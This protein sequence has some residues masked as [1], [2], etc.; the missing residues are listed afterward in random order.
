MAINFAGGTY[1]NAAV[2]TIED[3]SDEITLHGKGV[4]MAFCVENTGAALTAFQLQ[5]KVRH[6][7]TFH[8]V[9]DGSDWATTHPAVKYVKGTLATLASGASGKCVLELG[10][11][12]S[13]KFRASCGTTTATSLKVNARLQS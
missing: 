10:P 6:D 12:H 8:T 4:D 1:T 5:A 2:T 13:I 3:V 9:L 7:D 11:W